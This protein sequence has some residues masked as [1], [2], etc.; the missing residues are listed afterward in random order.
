MWGA[1]PPKRS[2]GGPRRPRVDGKVGG[3]PWRGRGRQG[4]PRRV[5]APRGC[6]VTRG[7]AGGSREGLGGHWGGGWG[8]LWDLGG[9][10]LVGEV[11]WGVPERLRET[12][13][14]VRAFWG[15]LRTGLGAQGGVW[16][17][18]GW[19]DSWL[20]SGGGGL[21]PSPFSSS[22]GHATKTLPGSPGRGAAG[23][24]PPA[25]SSRAKMSLTGAG[26]SPPGQSLALRLL[27]LP[28]GRPPPPTSPPA[29]PEPPPA[30]TEP[31]ARPKVHR[32]RKTMAKPSNGQVGGARPL[33][34]LWGL[35]GV[36]GVPRHC[37]PP[38]V[39]QSPPGPFPSP[40]GP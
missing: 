40:P 34:S 37:G 2:A 20:L 6:Q 24:A 39:P 28:G 3:G 38:Q 29:P 32:A 22:S 5:P 12:G 4:P 31:P 16:S 26:K 14:S 21:S 15:G 13:V 17:G 35:V 30:P 25:P 11:S 1:P 18:S 36:G 33:H 8:L 7:R 23:G 9:V 19:G 10:W 27:S